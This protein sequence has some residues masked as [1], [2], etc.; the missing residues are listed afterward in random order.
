MV[1]T[2]RS[3]QVDGTDAKVIAFATNRNPSDENYPKQ[4]TISPDGRFIVY[5][6]KENLLFAPGFTVECH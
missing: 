6:F 4:T 2:N 5:S 1:F 3:I